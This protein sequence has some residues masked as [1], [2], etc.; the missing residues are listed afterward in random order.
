MPMREEVGAWGEEGGFF[1]TLSQLSG[2]F[3]NTHA[4]LWFEL[5]LK[6]SIRT[7]VST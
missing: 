2:S 7:N 3:S 4:G 1:Q 5:L 6:H